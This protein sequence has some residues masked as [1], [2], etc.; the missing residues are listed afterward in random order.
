VAEDGL[1]PTLIKG[2]NTPFSPDSLDD[3][4]PV[5]LARQTH[6]LSPSNEN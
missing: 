1:E 4:G 5:I 2:R 3:S 6:Y